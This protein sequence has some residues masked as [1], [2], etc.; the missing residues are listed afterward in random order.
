MF[1]ITLIEFVFI[2]LLVAF[3]VTQMIIPI[4]RGR[5]L[6]PMF[7]SERN[8]LEA[9]IVGLTEKLD[10]TVLAKEAEELSK[11]LKKKK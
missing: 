3:V 11:Q 4:V 8:Q 7:R 10:D 6:F 9:K 2:A 5:Q 1:F